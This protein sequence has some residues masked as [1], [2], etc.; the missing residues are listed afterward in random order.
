MV[1]LE[2]IPF[3]FILF[4]LHAMYF[5]ISKHINYVEFILEDE[6]IA[7]QLKRNYVINMLERKCMHAP[8]NRL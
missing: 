3:A 5:N 7:F 8:L 2:Q 1:F 4:Q 6:L